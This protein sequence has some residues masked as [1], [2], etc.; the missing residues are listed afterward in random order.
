[1]LCLAALP[2]RRKVLKLDFQSEFSTSKIIESFWF[3]FRYKILGAHFLL[4][5]FFGK[6]NFKTTFLLKSGLIFDQ[7]AKLGKAS[8]D[9]Y[10]PGLWLILLDLLKNWVAE[11]VSSD[12]NDFI[13]ITLWTVVAIGQQPFFNLVL[14]Q[15]SELCFGW[16]MHS[17]N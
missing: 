16:W 4:K 13:F 6:I 8:R 12:V 7:A 1:M 17:R 5:W 3:L 9:A 15:K 11:S 2:A 10:N 14:W